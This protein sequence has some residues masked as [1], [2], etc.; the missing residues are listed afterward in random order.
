MY[1]DGNLWYLDDINAPEAWDIT[2]GNPDLVIAVIDTGANLN[3]TDLMENVWTNTKEIPDNGIDDDKNG[4]ID[5][6]HG[7]NFN[8]NNNDLNDYYGHGN[9]ISSMI[10]AKGNNG[11]GTTGVVWNAKL[12]I[13]KM[14]E[15]I[16]GWSNSV[17]IS[18]AIRYAVDNG[19]KII[20]F[21]NAGGKEE[22]QDPKGLILDALKYADK[23]GV[24]FVT[25][26][27]NSKN[28]NDVNSDMLSC[29]Y[30]RIENI[31]V[32]SATDKNREFAESFSSYGKKSVDLA[33]P[34][35]NMILPSIRSENDSLTLN[36]M[37]YLPLGNT[38]SDWKIYDSNLGEINTTPEKIKQI[39]IDQ[40][41]G[42]SESELEQNIIEN[43]SDLSSTYIITRGA[44][45][46]A[47]GTNTPFIL[48][49]NDGIFSII[50]A[51]YSI[52]E[53]EK[54]GITFIL[55]KK[56][57][58]SYTSVEELQKDLAEKNGVYQIGEILKGKFIESE[59]S[60]QIKNL[61]PSTIPDPI[62]N[63]EFKKLYGTEPLY[64][65]VIYSSTS[66]DGFLKLGRVQLTSNYRV[67]EVTNSNPE[68]TFGTSCSTPIVSGVAA[69]VWSANPDLSVAQVKE[70]ILSTVDKV[71]SLEDK[72]KT[73]GIVNAEAAVKK[74]K[75]MKGENAKSPF[76]IL[77]I[78]AGIGIAGIIAVKRR[79]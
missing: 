20:N 36:V 13:L 24:L 62:K 29:Y 70:C 52:P 61:L 26:A 56:P 43:E 75:T 76:P 37:N 50:Y 23:H 39:L 1:Q 2:T 41:G 59:N 49:G 15:P 60:E 68:K 73:G 6:I 65:G 12:M 64:L 8:L 46:T 3:Y 40:N 69:L 42:I 54:S 45:T 5:D 11:T 58:S 30:D 21:S 34:G 51:D 17:N 22:L 16:V 53:D 33:A 7:W 14:T 66:D 27:G 4:Y 38:N 35:T 74:A 18:S 28:D 63:D 44:K 47:V 57:L 9:M 10:G 72:T 71:P 31:I 67:V 32:V 77:G 25:A 48:N 55:T 79:N 78:L 19:A